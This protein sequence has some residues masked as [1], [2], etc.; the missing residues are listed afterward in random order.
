MLELNVKKSKCNSTNSNG[1]RD[2]WRNLWLATP[3]PTAVSLRGKFELWELRCELVQRMADHNIFKFQ[4][5]RPDAWR[6]SLISQHVLCLTSSLR[7]ISNY[8]CRQCFWHAVRCLRPN[9]CKEVG[10][11]DTVTCQCSPTSPAFV[12]TEPREHYQASVT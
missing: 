9:V 11:M 7:H 10:K 3:A 6:T 8:F 2:I 1:C 4:S 12:V 5:L